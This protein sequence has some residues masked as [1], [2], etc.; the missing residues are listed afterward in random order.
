MRNVKK[1]AQEGRKIIR[2]KD[3]IDLS[4]DEMKQILD[5]FAEKQKTVGTFDALWETV[6]DAFLM[7]IAVGHRNA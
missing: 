3:R 2:K 5:T 7:G 4:Y 6:S 1:Q